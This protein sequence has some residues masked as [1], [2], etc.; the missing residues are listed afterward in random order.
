MCDQEFL[1]DGISYQMQDILADIWETVIP[2]RGKTSLITY[3]T[4]L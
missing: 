3:V 1:L 2:N 4:S